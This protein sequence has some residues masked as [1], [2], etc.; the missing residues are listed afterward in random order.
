MNSGKYFRI[1]NCIVRFGRILVIRDVRNDV[2]ISDANNRIPQLT[3]ELYIIA[4]TFFPSNTDRLSRRTE[5]ETY[6]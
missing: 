4:T 5:I 6:N 2:L 1:L 3:I